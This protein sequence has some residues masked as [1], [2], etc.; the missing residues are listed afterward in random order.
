MGRGTYVSLVGSSG[1]GKSTLLA[2]LGGLERPQVGR[3]VVGGV[4]VTSL[5]ADEL[6][7]YRRT[8]VGFVFQHFGLLEALTALENIE[9][10]LALNGVGRIARHRRATEVLGDVGLASRTSHRPYELSGGERQRV[11]IARAIVN[12]PGLILADEP[13]GNLDVDSAHAVADLLA[14]LR[15]ERGCTLLVVTHNP[16]MAE[17]ADSHFA[18]LGGRLVQVSPSVATPKGD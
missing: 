12:E 4:D 10:A 16:A 9:L 3:V 11:A 7:Q 2:I 1:S 18:L 8:A 14:S 17:Q 13:T 6:A 5:N 15:R